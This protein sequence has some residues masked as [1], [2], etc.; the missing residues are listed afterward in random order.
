MHAGFQPGIEQVAR[1]FQ[2]QRQHAEGAVLRGVVLAAHGHTGL[3]EHL[4]GADHAAAVVGVQA[5]GGFGVHSGQAGMQALLAARLVRQGVELGAQAFIPA[6][7]AQRQPVHQR[8]EI[9]ARAAHQNRHPAARQNLRDHLFRR[10]GIVG[11][12][13]GFGGIGHIQHV[14]RQ[15]RALLRRGLGGADVHAPVDLHG[16][17]A[18]DFAP[19]ALGQLQAQIAFSAGSGTCHGDHGGLFAHGYG[20]PY[21]TR[22]KRFSSA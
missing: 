14:V 9:Q 18:D 17:H 11:H 3:L 15:E 22:L 7:A 2:R 5:G 13:V 4:N 10:H 8:L 1:P 20:L 21:C 16:V 6:R 12:G 19:K